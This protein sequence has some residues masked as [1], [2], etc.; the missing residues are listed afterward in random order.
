M[1][2]GRTI[3]IIIYAPFSGLFLFNQTIT[4]PCWSMIVEGEKEYMSS[5]YASA[6]QPTTRILP[7]VCQV[8]LKCLTLN[9]LRQQNATTTYNSGALGNGSFSM[10]SKHQL[11]FVW[12]SIFKLKFITKLSVYC[13]FLSPALKLCAES[14]LPFA[15]FLRKFSMIWSYKFSEAAG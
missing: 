10:N 8:K 13:I 15:R 12:H 9:D 11:N 6:M 14:H 3:A 1:A 4:V 7:N 5:S 2:L